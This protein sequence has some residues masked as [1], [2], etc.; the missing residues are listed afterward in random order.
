[1]ANA[2]FLKEVNGVK[3]QNTTNGA[4]SGCFACA[5]PAHWWRLLQHNSKYLLA[6]NSIHLVY[7]TANYL[8]QV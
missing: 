5:G 3:L 6:H 7:I 2:L 8:R 1:M 4:E